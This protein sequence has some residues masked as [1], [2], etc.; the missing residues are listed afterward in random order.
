MSNDPRVFYMFG[1]VQ[2]ST[3]LT[4]ESGMLNQLQYAYNN[5][6]EALKRYQYAVVRFKAT[7]IEVGGFNDVETLEPPEFREFI[8]GLL[9][10]AKVSTRVQ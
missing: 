9:Q 6:E 8:A 5:L 2:Y 7:E 4:N 1:E 3:F 10:Q